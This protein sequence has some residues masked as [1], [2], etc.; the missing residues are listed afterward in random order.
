MFVQY[1]VIV[2]RV[3]IMERPAVMAAK[4]FLGEVSGRIIHIRVGE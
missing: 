4:A 1:A 2:P 3:N